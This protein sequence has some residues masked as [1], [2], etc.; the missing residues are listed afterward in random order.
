MHAA[1]QWRVEASPESLKI[2]GAGLA[3]VVVADPG[4]HLTGLRIPAGLFSATGVTVGVTDPAAAPIS[5]SGFPSRSR[6]RRQSR[7]SQ[8]SAAS[9][10]ARRADVLPPTPA[11]RAAPVRSSCLRKSGPPRRMLL[12][13][14]AAHPAISIPP[15]TGITTPVTRSL[16]QISDTIAADTSSGSATRPSS[17]FTSIAFLIGS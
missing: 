11:A 12:C 9:A 7:L 3:T 8:L 16:P 15:S 10:V 17:D 5:R 1:P 6:C 2:P 13:P 4:G 14:T